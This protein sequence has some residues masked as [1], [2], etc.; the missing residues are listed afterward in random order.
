MNREFSYDQDVEGRRYHFV[1]GD[2]VTQQDGVRAVGISMCDDRDIVGHVT[3]RV[4]M[5]TLLA[6]GGVPSEE[7]FALARRQFETDRLARQLLNAAEQPTH[8]VV[9]LRL[10]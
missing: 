4:P 8:L 9:G 1:G 2:V 5:L 10:N 3:F 7:H 6:A